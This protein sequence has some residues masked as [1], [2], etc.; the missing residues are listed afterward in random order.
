[1]KT[2][3]SGQ[4]D[5]VWT[6]CASLDAALEVFPF[7]HSLL[8]LKWA[9]WQVVTL[10]QGKIFKVVSEASA[11]SILHRTKAELPQGVILWSPE[12]G[13]ITGLETRG[14]LVSAGALFSRW[15]RHFVGEMGVGCH[16]YAGFNPLPLVEGKSPRLLCLDNFPGCLNR[17]KEL[18]NCTKSSWAFSPQQ[19]CLWT[20]LTGR[21]WAQMSLSLQA[22]PSRT[23]EES[24]S[25]L[26]FLNL[27]KLDSWA[28]L[29]KCWC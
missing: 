5:F 23:Q 22:V 17:S 7:Q 18:E 14:L 20:P 1:M 13:Q 2:L 19:A 9:V 27:E 16:M 3:C 15:L 29:C 21:G 25:H 28:E 12:K 4:W 6:H 24:S 10:A 11:V 8:S 26:C